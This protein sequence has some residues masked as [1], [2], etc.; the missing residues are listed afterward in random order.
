MNHINFLQ[1]IWIALRET[2]IHASWVYLMFVYC[3]CV[4][5]KA[6]K[7]S[8]VQFT[9]LLIV[10][11]LFVY[12][13]LLQILQGFHVTLPVILVYV[14]SLF[15]A[16]F[17]GFFVAR[18]KEV[19]V[20]KEKKLVSLK[21]SWSTMIM[22]LL[23]F[24]TQFYFGYSISADPQMLQNTTFEYTMLAVSAFVTGLFLGQALCYIYCY[25]KGPHTPL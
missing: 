5:L 8:V 7:D 23:I 2:L 21:G 13:S 22:V 12:F 9:K 25:R 16:C 18:L 11:A 4:G 10:P 24:F 14:C 15:L 19:I 20:D 6:S 17:A 3:V 1:N